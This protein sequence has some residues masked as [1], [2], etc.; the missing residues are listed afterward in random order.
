ME[1]P[2]ESA[3]LDVV[4]AARAEKRTLRVCGPL[5]DCLPPEGGLV[6]LTLRLGRAFE[7]VRPV[8]DGLYV[9][10]AALL[11]PIG[12]RRGFEALAR[13]PG[14]LGDAVEEGW[15]T[16]MVK[17]VRRLRG[18]SV[19]E[20]TPDGEARGEAKAILLGAVLAPAKL[21]W[22]PRA[23][24]AFRPVKRRDL[25]ELLRA[26]GLAGLRLGDAALA[27]DDPAVLVNRG[28]ASARQIR[29]LL[30][31]ARERIHTAT[32]IELQERLVPPGKGGR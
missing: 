23:G 14:A 26:H 8:E 27:E 22:V 32:G 19:E 29:L 17:R 10:A 28:G 20:V 12:A 1:V 6:G 15:I 18:R 9:G 4:K 2:D 3:L 30:Q 21:P 7:E 13:A 24:E 31:A 11:A 16:P 5:A 25:R